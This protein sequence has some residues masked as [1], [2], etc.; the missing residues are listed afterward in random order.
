[1][2]LLGR[3][4][5]GGNRL[6]SRSIVAALSGVL[7]G[8]WLSA[9]D[10]VLADRFELAAGSLFLGSTEVG[11]A[12]EEPA[13]AGAQDEVW[14]KDY[15]PADV[16]EEEPEPAA[17]F[18]VK[19]GFFIG[20]YLPVQNLEGELDGEGAFVEPLEVLLSPQV[21]DGVGFG[22]SVG[23][24]AQN[25]SLEVGYQRTFHD[26]E[27]V[28]PASGDAALNLVNFDLKVYP[29]SEIRIQPTIQA[30]FGF[31]WLD[32]DGGVLSPGGVV[33]GDAT[34]FG[35]AGELGGGLTFYPT[36]EWGISAIAGYRLLYFSDAWGKDVSG[37]LSDGIDAHGWFFQF[38]MTYTF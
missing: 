17:P 35:I 36:P 26:W 21:D 29:W 23:G 9:A 16:I 1:M 38:G 6:R 24:R 15:V 28:A 32:V 30:G 34:Y 14:P 31:A 11:L 37:V 33:I 12:E 13:P 22:V 7:S 8:G 2:A 25:F 10:G 5:S 3:S 19:Q 20:V 4:S 27:H 18:R